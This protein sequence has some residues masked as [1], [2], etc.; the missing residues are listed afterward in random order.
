[1]VKNRIYLLLFVVILVV[2]F[3]LRFT[4]VS[5]IP[6]GVNRDEA[7]I[8]YTAYSLLQTGKDEYG[9][10]YPLSFQSFGDWKLPL[11][12]YTT[13]A[14][15]NFLGLNDFAVRLPSVV[16]G[17]A[18]IALIFFLTEELF[19]S[20][21]LSFLAMAI[22]AIAPWNI[23]LSRIGAET[24]LAVFLASLAFLL[25]LKGIKK[26][27][28]L[29][30][31]SAVFFALTYFTYAGNY[32]FTTLLC[33]GIVLIY[34]YKIPKTKTSYVAAGIFIL[35][36]I[37]IGVTTLSANH[38]K[39]SGI[40]IFGDPA[41]VYAKIDIPRNEHTNPNSLFVKLT[42]NKIVFGTE[43]F[44]QNYFN[45]FSVPFLFISGGT[46]KSY[47]I[48]D[49]GNMYL[50]EAPFLFMGIVFL[51]T[52]KKGRNRS[53]VLWWLFI[54]P[55]AASITK[56]A[57]HS[58]RMFAIFPILPLVTACGIY[59][60]LQMVEKRQVLKIITIFV[61][62]SF[63]TFN[64]LVYLD[65]YFILFPLNESQNWGYGYKKI[66]HLLEEPQYAQKNVIMSAPQTS[67]YIFLVFYSKYNP[68]LLQKQLVHYPITEDGFT[69]VKSYGK[70]IFKDINWGED[71]RVKNTLLI[72]FSK[73]VPEFIKHDYKTT[74]ILLPNGKPMFT[75]VQI[76]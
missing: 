2:G 57:P 22:T 19:G 35:I 32:I 61:I 24:N 17:V 59:W 3:F 74:D 4:N 25:F 30:V 52:Q 65:Q 45:A 47:N 16:A 1:M 21:L 72:D 67:P 58:T 20:K 34:W 14:S 39:I 8:G 71:T 46:N 48:N 70:Y 7:S 54:S 37:F 6:P 64:F 44:L 11:Y 73:D 12:I 10:S 66:V 53:I 51:F 5:D 27:A 31:P 28:W 36:S 41:V 13:A 38:T 40:G 26:H 42:H 23:Q 62:I 68:A 9:R 56:D 63:Y 18:T 76:P 75:I 29:L 50:I 60:I 49:F 69:H 55:I 33:L 43:R 15:V